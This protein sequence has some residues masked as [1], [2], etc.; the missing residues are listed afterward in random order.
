MRELFYTLAILFGIGLLT[1]INQVLVGI[2]AELQKLND[3]VED[4][5]GI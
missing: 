2:R 1:S 4:E 5:D 3:W